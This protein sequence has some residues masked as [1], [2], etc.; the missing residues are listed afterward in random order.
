MGEIASRGQL[1]MSFVRWALVTVPGIVLLGF[2]SAAISGSG[3]T[4]GWYLALE[5]PALQPPPIAFPIAWTILY[6]MMGIALAMILS[7]RGARGRTVAI[8][9]FAAQLVANLSWSPVF[10]GLHQVSASLFVVAAMFGLTFGTIMA[11]RRVRP[12]AALLLLP[13]LAWIMFAAYLNWEIRRLNPDAE[14][15]AP[16]RSGTQFDL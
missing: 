12:K 5:K 13:Y 11:F 9:L 1:R 16:V 10:F 6:V 14:T 15:L 3:A 8:A 2:A 4:G 7:A